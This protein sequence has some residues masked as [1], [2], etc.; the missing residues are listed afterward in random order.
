EG[1]RPYWLHYVREVLSIRFIDLNP[2]AENAY[3]KMLSDRDIDTSTHYQE[4]DSAIPKIIPDSGKT[5]ED[6]A[7]FIENIAKPEDL[8]IRNVQNSFRGW[9][10]TKYGNTGKLNEAWQRELK[11]FDEI[12]FYPHLPVGSIFVQDDWLDFVLG[13]AISKVQIMPMA[14]MDFLGYLRI[15]HPHFLNEDGSVYIDAVNA[16]WETSFDQELDLYP[17]QYI[18][19]NEDYRK[20][21]MAFARQGLSPQHIRIEYSPAIERDYRTQL[22][23]KYSDIGA[24][25]EAWHLGYASFELLPYPMQDIDYAAFRE[26]QGDIRWEFVKRNYVMVLDQ[27]LNDARSLRNTLIYCL[28]SILMAVTVNPLAAYALSRFKPRLTYQSI[29]FFMLT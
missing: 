12:R 13:D 14:Q 7:Y 17:A 26:R 3:R 11:S 2:S 8:R 22:R 6:Y 27:M 5:V 1:L 21:W 25:N 24:L 29:M 28:L 20:V 16:A 18:P 15:N 19:Q 23:S 4:G 10:Q 9:L